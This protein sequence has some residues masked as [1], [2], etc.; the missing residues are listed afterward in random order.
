MNAAGHLSPAEAAALLHPESGLTAAARLDLSDHAAGCAECR[1]L[2]DGVRAANRAAAGSP[3]DLARVFS[4]LIEAGRQEADSTP[5]AWL[6]EEEFTG[7]ALPAYTREERAEMR[8]WQTRLD[9]FAE[10]RFEP[11]GTLD[12]G[13]ETPRRRAMSGRET[14][15]GS[16]WWLRLFSWPG[17]TLAGGIAVLILATVLAVPRARR[18]EA[19]RLAA[20]G[21]PRVRADIEDGPVEVRANGGVEGIASLPSDLRDAV[22]ETVRRGAAPGALLGTLTRGGS[23]VA[24]TPAADR[25]PRDAVPLSPVRT[26]VE[27]DRPVFRWQSP[28]KGTTAAAVEVRVQP[29]AGGEALRSGP[30]PAGT[31]QWTPSAPLARGA[32]YR[33]QVW[34]ATADRP[35][36]VPDPGTRPGSVFKILSADARARLEALRA[37]AAGRSH[38]TLGVAYAREGL[39]EEAAREFQALREHNAQSALAQRLLASVEG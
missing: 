4:G 13:K 18:P 27:T 6:G 31:T 15:G 39:R 28:G 33:W 24:A 3:A 12:P 29:S 7:G 9:D 37:G 19:G 35:N 20:T 2:L 30:L 32:L 23:P 16:P 11:G 10:E 34:P 17:L 22:L 26:S 36:A 8:R 38:L 25:D 14:T 21:S 5:E 1:A